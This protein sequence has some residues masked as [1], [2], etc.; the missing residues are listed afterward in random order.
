[1]HL[2]II[3]GFFLVFL[4][5]SGSCKLYAEDSIPRFVN[6]STYT[7]WTKSQQQTYLKGSID[8]FWNRI[9]HEHGM[10]NLFFQC[11]REFETIDQFWKL[12]DAFLEL[13][14]K[15]YPKF[16]TAE[17]FSL[18]VVNYCKSTK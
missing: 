3:Y 4:M 9:A 5:F 7:S 17:I 10:D 2:K 15:K 16:S 8:T 18:A 14:V 6:V 12:F 11:T 1:M 13:N